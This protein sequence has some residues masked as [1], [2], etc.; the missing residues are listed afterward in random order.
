MLQ[1]FGVNYRGNE[2]YAV[3]EA[4]DEVD[5]LNAFLGGKTISEEINHY[6]LHPE[7]VEICEE[8]DD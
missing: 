5:A 3:V 1:R 4:E 2:I 7:F 6:M 8:E